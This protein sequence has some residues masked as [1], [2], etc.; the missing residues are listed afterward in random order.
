MKA[1]FLYLYYYRQG[2]V[3]LC[4]YVQKNPSIYNVCMYNEKGFMFS[5]VY[6][7]HTGSICTTCTHKNP[8]ETHFAELYIPYLSKPGD[9]LVLLNGN[10]P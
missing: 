8:T 3:C 6:V 10:L 4:I 5:F 7:S 9:V 1:V 2:F